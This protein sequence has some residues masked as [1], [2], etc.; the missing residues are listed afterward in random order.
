MLFSLFSLFYH[1]YYI[2]LLSLSSL[3]YLIRLLFI[4]CNDDLC[5]ISFA[6]ESVERAILHKRFIVSIGGKADEEHKNN[7][8]TELN[9]EDTK[10][11]TT[12]CGIRAMSGIANSFVANYVFVNWKFRLERR[13]R[14][15]LIEHTRLSHFILF[16]PCDIL[17][18]C[19]ALAESRC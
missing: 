14:A 11:K 18:P 4:N 1:Y 5:V 15:F 19:A 8:N 12:V 9:I 13:S 7:C 10:R 2:L 6:K 16:V 17:V 3:Y